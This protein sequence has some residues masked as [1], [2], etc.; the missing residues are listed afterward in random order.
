MSKRTVVFDFD[1]VIH[2]YRSGWKGVDV[3]PDPPVPGIREAIVELRADGYEV[4]CVSTRCSEEKGTAAVAAYL[5]ANGIFVDHIM[6][7]KPPAICYVDDRAIRFDGDASVIVDQVRNFHSWTEG[8][9]KE[10]RN[11]VP[12]M[13]QPLIEDG[14]VSKLRPCEASHYE[15]GEEFH[16][17]GR[18]HGFFPEYQ[19]FDAGPGNTTVALVEQDDG[20]MVY[21]MPVTVKFL[22]RDGGGP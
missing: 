10:S 3:I 16:V 4:V 14:P 13:I 6:S 8:E 19:D 2:S 9:R 12:I 1:G 21:C 22:D 7:E 18:F 5:L 15:K 11:D 20:Q 17:C